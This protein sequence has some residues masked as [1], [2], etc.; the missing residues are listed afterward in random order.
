MSAEIF[1]PHGFLFRFGTSPISLSFFRRAGYKRRQYIRGDRGHNPPEQSS[2][3]IAVWDGHPSVGMIVHPL[4][5]ASVRQRSRPAVGKVFWPLEYYPGRVRAQF[6]TP[7]KETPLRSFYSGTS[8]YYH[9][10][11]LYIFQHLHAI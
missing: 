9:I 7:P 2:G 4:E 6:V 10:I 1:E 3:V 11:L 5:R 8:V